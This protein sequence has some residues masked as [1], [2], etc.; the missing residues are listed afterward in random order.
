MKGSE[1]K[2]NKARLELEHNGQIAT[3]V[4]ATPKANILDRVMMADVHKIFEELVSRRDVKAIV[5][6]GDGP[7]FSYGASLQEHLPEHMTGTLAQLRELFLLVAEAPAP[8]IA[9]VRGQC[10][11]GGFELVLACDLILAD[12]T[13]QFGCP[14]IKLGVFP[15]A[16][17]ALLPVRVGSA[18]ASNI[19]LTEGSWMGTEAARAGLVARLARTGEL[20]V[21]LRQWL[22]ADFLPQP[23][24]A[25]RHAARA[26]RLPIL[27]ALKKDL[28]RL[29]KM[30][31]EELMAEPDAMEG[32]RAFLE[33]RPP[34][35]AQLKPPVG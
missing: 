32:I 27:S 19:I 33:K 34:E 1:V 9:A 29:E 35:W 10:L 26:V 23:A 16:A 7:N 25:L 22:E 13:A 31:L 18:W 6:T 8:T 15:P 20:D 4:L 5:V 21:Q 17:S 2:L 12:E 11:G 28:P 14:E 3:V 24:A 30:Y